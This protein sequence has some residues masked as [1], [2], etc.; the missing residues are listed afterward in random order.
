MLSGCMNRINVLWNSKKNYSINHLDRSYN[1][2]AHELSKK[3]LAIQLGI[4]KMEIQMR[5]TSYQIE[6]FS[7]PGT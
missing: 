3:G 5:S 2:R 6:D 4:R 1:S 7:L